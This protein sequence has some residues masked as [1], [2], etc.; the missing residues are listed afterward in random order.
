MLGS[1]I[2]SRL[3]ALAA[4]VALQMRYALGM[5]CEY[6]YRNFSLSLPPGHML[7]FYR[8][9]H[10]T[11]DRFLPHL[12][13]HL[14]A[15]SAVIDVGAN[16]GDTAAGMIDVNPYLRYACIEPDPLFF[17]YL[18]KNVERILASQP[19]VAI[20]VHRA[21]I[22]K[23][24]AQ[25]GLVGSKGTK[26][27]IPADEMTA[28]SAPLESITLDTLLARTVTDVRLLKSD[29]DGFDYDVLDSAEVLIAAHQPLLF[30]ECH[31]RNPAQ[32]A[33]YANTLGSLQRRGYDNW[34]VFDNYGD[35]LHRT[36][37]IEALLQL[38]EYVERQNQRRTTR[39]IYYFDVLAGTQRDRRLLQDALSSYP[40]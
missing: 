9:L 28:T 34:I 10:S 11:Y 20:T 40:T 15:G 7:P 3:G 37:D 38:L 5:R 2:R 22:G 24:V 19:H 39:T 31:F 18:L 8:S 1:G 14:P 13:K 25:A 36:S 29:V 27:A 26:H 21:L 32:K 33:G 4:L 16:C 6:R 17:E 23:A 12:A 30:F 35:M